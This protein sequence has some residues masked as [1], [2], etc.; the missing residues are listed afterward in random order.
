MGRDKQSRRNTLQQ[1]QE[2]EEVYARVGE[3]LRRH[4][5]AA[6]WW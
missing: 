2:Y 4:K 1:T 6:S 5:H 3:V